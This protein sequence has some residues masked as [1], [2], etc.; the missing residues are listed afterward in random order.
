MFEAQL[1]TNASQT[2][3]RCTSCGVQGRIAARDFCYGQ[4][5][6]IPPERWIR[7]RRNVGWLKLGTQRLVVQDDVQIPPL[8]RARICDLRGTILGS[9]QRATIPEE[10]VHESDAIL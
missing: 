3:N 10:F 5:R 4:Q 9:A 2:E 6:Q 8:L 7:T 1:L